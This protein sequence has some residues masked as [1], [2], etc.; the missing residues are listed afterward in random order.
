MLIESSHEYLQ[1][2]SFIILA[3]TI[4]QM[5]LYCYTIDPV[6]NGFHVHASVPSRPWLWRLLAS[7]AAQEALLA[8]AFI[9]R[10]AKLADY[11]QRF[12]F[13][14]TLIQQAIAM[15]AMGDEASSP[16]EVL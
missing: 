11:L 6:L 7:L 14:Q 1:I 4:C 8:I 3:K 13:L 12:Q 2:E 16:L 5:F 10:Q 15:F 9:S